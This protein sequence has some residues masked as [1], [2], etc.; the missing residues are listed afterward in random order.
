MAPS[1]W[2]SM[3]GVLPPAPAPGLVVESH[4]T[5][6]GRYSRRLELLSP[7]ELGATPFLCPASLFLHAG[8]R[9]QRFH[10]RQTGSVGV[11]SEPIGLGTNNTKFIGRS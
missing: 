9:D 11:P 6:I 3:A 1:H 5:L 7:L 10:M 8:I 4:T 2:F